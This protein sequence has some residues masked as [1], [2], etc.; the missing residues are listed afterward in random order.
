M[1]W[2]FNPGTIGFLLGGLGVTIEL[3]AISI[4]ISFVIGMFLAL[5]RLSR[6]PWL[7]IPA[8]F[9]IEV[10]RALPL[11][12]VI[13]YTYFALPHALNLKIP[14]FVAGVIAMSAFTSSLVAEI[15]RAG[16][17]AVPRGIVEAAESQGFGGTAIMR[18]VVLPIALRNMMPALVSQ[19][20]TLLKDTSLTAIITIPELLGR[21]QIVFAAPP[22]Q[23]LPVFALVAVMYFAVNFSL[24]QAGRRLEART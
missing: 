10:M 13:V 8:T 2:L 16:I 24:S 23:P 17:L 1:T 15:I 21:A 22:F 19:F 7:R 20:V 14:P 11:L 3:A 18:M 5:G 4:A 12:L 9:Y 6:I